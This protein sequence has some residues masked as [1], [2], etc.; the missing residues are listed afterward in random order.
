MEQEPSFLVPVHPQPQSAEEKQ[1]CSSNNTDLMVKSSKN[2]I[3]TIQ[4][5]WAVAGIHA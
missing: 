4:D 2:Y 5:S 3:R 1:S